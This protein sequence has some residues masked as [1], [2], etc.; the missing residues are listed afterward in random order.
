LFIDGL[1]RLHVYVTAGGM[2][3]VAIL[4]LGARLIEVEPLS[5]GPLPLAALPEEADEP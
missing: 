4:E 5:D 3:D 1:P 2:V